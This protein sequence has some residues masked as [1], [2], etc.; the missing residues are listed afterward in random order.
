MVLPVTHSQPKDPKAAV[1]LPLAVKK[2]LGLDDERSWI[3]VSEG[4]EF[5]WPASI[6]ASA[7][8][9]SATSTGFSRRSCSIKCA[10]RSWRATTAESC[11]GHPGNR[12]RPAC[13]CKR[14]AMSAKRGPQPRPSSA[15][16]SV[17]MSRHASRFSN[18][19]RSR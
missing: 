8:A 1:E 18:G 4:N 12:G 6:F 13:A 3:V 9:A 16:F 15:A 19:R 14:N 17:S 10:K 5:V 7:G 11:G 2:H